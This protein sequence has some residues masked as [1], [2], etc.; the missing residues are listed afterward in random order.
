M[1]NKFYLNQATVFKIANQFWRTQF[2][3][4]YPDA[5]KE[6]RQKAWDAEKVH[7]RIIARRTLHVLERDG[8]IITKKE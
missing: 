3:Q 8:L 4:Y 2:Q 5:T 1:D 7:A 6:E